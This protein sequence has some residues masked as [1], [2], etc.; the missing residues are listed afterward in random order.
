MPE[1]ADDIH[2]AVDQSFPIAGIPPGR[3][4]LDVD[5]GP[6]GQDVKS[7]FKSRNTFVPEF[8]AEPTSGAQQT[9]ILVQRIT[10]TAPAVGRPVEPQ[11]V[12]YNRD[13]VPGH[14]DIEFNSIRA[15]INGRPE[16]SQRIFRGLHPR[17]AVGG[18]H[19]PAGRTEP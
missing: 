13:A 6:A 4:D 11:I 10:D 2:A 19:G 1:A 8:F 14:L 7:F 3:L 9:Q 12:D 15:V 16:S 18:N 17:P 5:P